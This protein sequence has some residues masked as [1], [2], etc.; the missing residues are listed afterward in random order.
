M[1]KKILVTIIVIILM[2]ITVIGCIKILN[3]PIH[4]EINKEDVL[5]IES[6]IAK[7]NGTTEIKDTILFNNIINWFNNSYDIRANP[8]FAGTTPEVG[9]NIN[10]KSGKCISLRDGPADFDV[11]RDDVGDKI[12]S[13]FAKQQNISKYLEGLSKVLKDYRENIH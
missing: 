2:S 11:Q 7:E 1:N 12:V 4:K 5:S 13:Y 8:E 6:W 10:L 9:I 3:K